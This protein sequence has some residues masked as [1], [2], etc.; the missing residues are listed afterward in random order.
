MDF[1][2][3]KLEVVHVNDKKQPKCLVE[4]ARWPLF[5]HGAK[6]NFL[7]VGVTVLFPIGTTVGMTVESLTEA[8]NGLAELCSR[9]QVFL[10]VEGRPK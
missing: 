10:R 3:S 1:R 4:V 2:P 5:R 6:T 8:H 7:N 9:K